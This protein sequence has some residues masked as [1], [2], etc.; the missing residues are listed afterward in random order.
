M[1]SARAFKLVEF[2][3][4]QHIILERNDDFFIDGRPYLDKIV[5]R[6]IKDGSARTIALENGEVHLSAFEQNPRDIARLKKNANI[7]ATPQGYGAIGP[8]AWLAFNTK[9]KPI[10]DVRCHRSSP[11][12]LTVTS[13]SRR[14]SS[15]PHRRP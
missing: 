10:S 12:P 5:M 8:I 2:K 14:S 7:S 1:W 4:D 6:I 3:R 13:S 9:R 15:G 11:T